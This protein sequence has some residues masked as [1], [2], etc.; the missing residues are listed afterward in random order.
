MSESVP[1]ALPSINSDPVKPLDA[2]PPKASQESKSGNEV[3]SQKTSISDSQLLGYERIDPRFVM[4][5]RIGG[6]IGWAVVA[7]CFVVGLGCAF[8]FELLPIIWLGALA[9]LASALLCWIGWMAHAFPRL[10]YES[11]GWRL[12]DCGFVIRTGVYWRKVVSVP[13][14]RV[15][16]ADVQQGPLMR[17]LGLAKLVVHTAGTQN[18][19]VEI[20]G[21][22]RVVAEKVRDALVENR[23]LNDGV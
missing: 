7:S 13:R 11:T 5:E 10:Q 16:H 22:N 4:L 12:D 21:L 8:A 1:E 23:E 17:S 2:V 3:A 18:A 20:Q 14:A 15:Q 9:L 19:S 6:W